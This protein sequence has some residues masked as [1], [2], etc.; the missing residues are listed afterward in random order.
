MT[1]CS[2]PLPSERVAAQCGPRASFEALGVLRY[3]IPDEHLPYPT[4]PLPR[5]RQ[6]LRIEG[7][8]A[9]IPPL[10]PWARSDVPLIPKITLLH[11]HSSMKSRN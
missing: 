4:E 11:T 8:G 2:G 6:A 10:R 3:L 1:V 5:L 7:V 9:G